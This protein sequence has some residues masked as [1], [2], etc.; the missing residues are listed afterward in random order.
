M[1]RLTWICHGSTVANREAR[2]P[3]DEPLDERAVEATKAIASLLQRADHVFASPALRARQTAEALGLA[4]ETADDLADCDY[5]RWAGRSI[6][7]LQQT[8]AENL[9]GW[10]TQPDE[11]PHGSE[12]VTAMCARVGA[13]MD[14]HLRLGGHAIAVTHAAILR[15]A[16]VSAL[17]APASSYWLS[18]IEPLA[19]VRMTS[20]GNRWALRLES[21]SP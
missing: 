9:A 18:D 1:T 4:A 15:A 17:K 5:G 11:T 12:S 10:M 21:A 13:W 6:Y 2:F 16:I 3:L 7:D 8:E 14:G 20:N 19:I